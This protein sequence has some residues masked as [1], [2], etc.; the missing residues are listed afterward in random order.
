MFK[1]CGFIRA[2]K[3]VGEDTKID[4]DF[5]K[6]FIFF[7]WNR[8]GN[9]WALLVLCNPMN[10]RDIS[11]DNKLSDEGAPLLLSFDSLESVNES[12]DK[13]TPKEDLKVVRKRIVSY[14][15]KVAS[16]DPKYTNLLKILAQ[17]DLD[18]DNLIP[19]VP[20]IGE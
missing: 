4:D 5:S 18:I 10:F 2:C 19:L 16:S 9:H 11:D 14:L 7:P 3:N 20:I 8:N 1:P 15:T 17:D 12:A 6:K 13:Y